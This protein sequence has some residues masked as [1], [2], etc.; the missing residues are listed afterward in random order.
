MLEI[1]VVLA[2]IA[3]L[4]VLVRGG[5]RMVSKADLVED[6][7]GLSAMIRRTSELAIEHGQMHRIVL[8]LDKEAYVV[9]VCEG[10]TTIARNEAVTN[11]AVKKK[12]A[13][14]RGQLQLQTMPKDAFSAGD[15]AETERRAIALAAAHVA[16]KD[17][18]AV[19]DLTTGDASGRRWGRLLAAS[20]GIKFKQIYTEH[21]DDPTTKGQVALY[22]WPTGS[23]EKADIELTD[24]D[25]V[26]S[27]LVYGLTGRVELRDGA[28]RDVNDH[29]LKN[30]MG[31]KDAARENT[32]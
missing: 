28:L 3:G 30:V 15:P 22:F 29:M 9:E 27:I 26:F 24:G 11:D 18:V 6:A 5:F 23:S 1:M 25:A 20:K 4:F 7:T 17:C 31:D 2:I 16:D 13:L 14:D 32:K 21:N 10:A 19:T 12:D 8:D